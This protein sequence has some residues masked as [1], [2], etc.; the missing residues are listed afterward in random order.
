MKQTEKASLSI[1]VKLKNVIKSA[2]SSQN[3]FTYEYLA[4]LV[5][6]DMGTRI[7]LDDDSAGPGATSNKTEI[8][9]IR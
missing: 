4:R 9:P 7:P 6:N 3:L 2:A 1:P 8:T 5:L